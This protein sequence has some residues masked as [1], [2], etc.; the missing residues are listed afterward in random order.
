[1]NNIASDKD[2]QVFLNPFIKQT[3]TQISNP[4]H[5]HI[6]LEVADLSGRVVRREVEIDGSMILIDRGE[7]VAGTYSSVLTS[8]Y[9]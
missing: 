8:K 9:W 4:V 3:E 6:V 2:V 5:T 1:V 7:L